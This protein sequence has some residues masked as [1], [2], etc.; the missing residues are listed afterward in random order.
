MMLDSETIT[1]VVFYPKP[2]PLNYV[3][4]GIATTTLANGVEIAGYL[5]ECQ[6]SHTLLI[7]FHGNGEMAVDYDALVSMYLDCGVSCW[8]V[9]YRGY[10]RSTG[11][12]SISAMFRDAEAI[13]ADVPR[14][15]KTIGRDF[16]QVIVM[17][18][19]LG[20]ASAIHLAAKGS[21]ALAGLI[22]DSA[23]A[24]GLALIARLGGPYILK[25][26]AFVYETRRDE[27]E[28][29]PSV[30]DP[31][32]PQIYQCPFEDNVDK[33]QR[34]HLP[35]LVIHG[36]DDHIIPLSDAIYLFKIC[37]SEDKQIVKVKGAGHNTLFSVGFSE[38]R[39][40]LRAYLSR[41]IG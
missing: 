16:S 11:M 38:Y 29:E 39:Q 1:Q 2:E 26:H 12:P 15:G 4:T 25:K 20:S 5:H 18:R 8:V 27:L 40:A 10:G 14:I 33:M 19:S 17:G 9:D 32:Q 22:L 36:T 6:A 3:P 35:I 7:I 24:D 37:P 13:L 34:C 23:Y 21:P 28:P 41:L 30:L 31:N